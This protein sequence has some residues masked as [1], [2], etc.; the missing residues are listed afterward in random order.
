MSLRTTLQDW[1]LT[2]TGHAAA[3]FVFVLFGLVAIGRLIAG[4]VFPAGYDGFM[5]LLGA[6]LGFGTAGMVGKRLSD[7]E[8]KKAG[9][10]PITVEAPSSV[11]VTQ[12]PAPQVPG[13]AIT[14]D[15]D[16]P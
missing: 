3:I 11:T 15:V 12:P 14:P 6:A 8:Y 5:A 7:V 9:T 1:P 13:V 4:A 10:S 2:N 16:K